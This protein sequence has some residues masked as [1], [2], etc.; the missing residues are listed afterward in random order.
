[1]TGNFAVESWHSLLWNRGPSCRGIVAQVGV[2]SVAGLPWNTQIEEQFDSMCPDH[3][4]EHRSKIGTPIAER[5]KE[6]DLIE[7]RIDQIVSERSNIDREIK[8]LVVAT[9]ARDE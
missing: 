6:I 5:A 7:A 9:N 3:R 8:S 2:E 1:M 4:P